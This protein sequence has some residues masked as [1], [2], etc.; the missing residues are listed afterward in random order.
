M[1]C[2]YGCEHEAKFQLKNGKW[3]CE[4]SSNKCLEVRRKNSENLK[5]A[6]KRGRKVS[7]DDTA[8]AKAQQTI[9]QTRINLREWKLANIP[10]EQLSCINKKRKVMQEQNNICALCGTPSEWNGKPL[11]FATDHINGNHLDNRRENIRMICPNCHSQTETFG[12]RNASKGG[13]Q[14]IRENASAVFSAHR[15]K[16]ILKQREQKE[17]FKKSNAVVTQMADV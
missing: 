12:S 14:K 6:F 16:G 13:K 5:K 9:T 11:S 1:L 2:E 7:F 4:P 8:R 17:L 3:C 10:F 15:E